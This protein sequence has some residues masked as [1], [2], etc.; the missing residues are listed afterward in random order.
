[1]DRNGGAWPAADTLCAMAK[2]RP[3]RRS[4]ASVQRPSAGA[5]PLQQHEAALRLAAIVNS[6]D[7]AIV[8][9]TLEGII[10]SWNPAAE[11]MFGWAA[12]E[13]IGKSITIIIPPDRLDEEENVLAQLLRGQMIDHYE[14]M[15]V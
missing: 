14:T 2:R 1:M 12:G 5:L 13:V 10:V 4:Q 7:D 8:S 11:R 6:S 3:V 9:K 15:R